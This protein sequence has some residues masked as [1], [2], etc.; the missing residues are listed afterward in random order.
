MAN[1]EVR[2]RVDRLGLPFNRYGLDKY[3]VSKDH[4]AAF[5]TLLEPFY[6]RY[7]TVDCCG[8]DHVPNEGGV[9]LVG[10]HSGGVPVD[11]AMVLSSMF[12]EME[13]PRLGHGMV[14]KFANRWPVVSQWFSRVGQFTGL[15]KHAVQLLQDDRVLMVFPEGTRGIG[16][17]YEDRYKLVRFGTG[18]MRIALEAGVPIVPFAFVGGEEAH[19]TMFHLDTLAKILGVPYIP[20]PPHLVPIPLPVHCE[21]HYGEPMQFDGTGTE[22]DERIDGYIQQVKDRIAA[23]IEKGR[24]RRRRQLEG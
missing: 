8:L 18:F 12:F 22:A 1:A 23:L 14:D 17:L 6:R 13:P 5:F 20:V 3:G 21:I 10:N 2:D 11:G 16:K 19:P 15:P 4:V 7:F 9:M 24:A